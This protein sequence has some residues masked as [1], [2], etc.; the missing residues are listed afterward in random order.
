MTL[1][2]LPQVEYTGT[3]IHPAEART[4]RPDP[5]SQSVPVLC[6]DIELD[7]ATRNLLH[8]EQPFPAGQ[9]KQCEAAAH[10]LKKGSRVTVTTP[11]VGMRL[12]A[13][14]ASHIHI[15]NQTLE[16]VA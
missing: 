14:N 1:H 12:V 15:I 9:H 3:L 10:R 5:L 16:A 8:V 11:L 6:L 4:G 13:S 7:S 2:T